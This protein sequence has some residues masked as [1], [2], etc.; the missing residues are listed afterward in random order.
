[1][2]IGEQPGDEEDRKGR[3]FVGPAGRLFDRALEEAGIDRSTVFVT[4]AEKH[5]KFEERGK[6]RLHKK[7]RMSEASATRWN[8]KC[9]STIS[10]R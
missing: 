10:K 8:I 1:M 2:F 5:F 7:P 3:P 9:S 4:N 6:R